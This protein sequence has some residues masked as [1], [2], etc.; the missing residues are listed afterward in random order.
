MKMI[1]KLI[2][3]IVIV[4]SQANVNVNALLAHYNVANQ[5]NCT[6]NK[7]CGNGICYKETY[8][9]KTSQAVVITSSE[10]VCYTPYTDFEGK[11]CSYRLR[12]KSMAFLMSFLLG[13]LGVDW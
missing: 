2:L 6:S 8:T 9:E 11:V 4:S 7:E 10:C 13:G 5:V 12:V 3:M 1:S